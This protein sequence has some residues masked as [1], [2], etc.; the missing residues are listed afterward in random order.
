MPNFTPRG[1]W[2]CDVCAVTVAGKFV[3]YEI[4]LSLA[5]LRADARKHHRRFIHRK[6]KYKTAAVYKHN[7]LRAGATHGPAL[8]Y[9]VVTPE[10]TAHVP[11]WA[12]VYEIR[13]RHV[14]LVRRAPQLH[15]H[16]VER[17]FVTLMR[18]SAEYRF[19]RERKNV[20]ESIYPDPVPSQLTALSSTMET[21]TP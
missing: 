20:C 16:R 1:W 8:F 7:Q 13:G 21:V 6:G 11:Q 5:D 19:W 18:E 2:E 9:Y 14:H 15:R 12:G 4:K 10:L 17:S 3:E